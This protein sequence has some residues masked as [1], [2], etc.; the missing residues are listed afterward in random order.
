M[1]DLYGHTEHHTQKG[2]MIAQYSAI[3]IEVIVILPL[4]LCFASEVQ[5]DKATCM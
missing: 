3:V 5:Q 1:W 2:L 4:N